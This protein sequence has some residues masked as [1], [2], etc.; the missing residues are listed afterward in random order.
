MWRRGQCSRPKPLRLP[1]RP[2][3]E[4][5]TA[6]QSAPLRVPPAEPAVENYFNKSVWGVSSNGFKQFERVKSVSFGVDLPEVC[7]NCAPLTVQFSHSL[8][9]QVFGSQPPTPTTSIE[10]ATTRPKI[11]LRVFG[12]TL[13][14]TSVSN[15]ASLLLG[16]QK[17]NTVLY[18][19]P[20]LRNL[21]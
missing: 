8:P 1:P 2:R 18:S 21:A 20:T 9:W 19:N 14:A 6:A 13:G 5:R 16:E 12:D 11:V 3:P 4:Q 15:P 7:A 10:R 17:A